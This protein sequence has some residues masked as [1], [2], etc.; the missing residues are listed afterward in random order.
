MILTRDLH[1][2]YED[3]G[4]PVLKNI[5]MEIREGKHVAI[6]GPN[7]C[8]KTTLVKHLN[9]L[10]L[11]TA[12]EVLV[13]EMD[14]RDSRN[15]KG[16][17]Q[18]VGMVF[19]NP[20]DQIVGMTVEEDVAFGPGNLNM[21]PSE[22][23]NRVR[24]SLET[25]GMDSH[26]KRPPQALSNGEK[27]LVAIAGV[28]ATEPKYLILDE[29]TTYLDPLWKQ[30]VM[31]LTLDL[32]NHG[33]TIIHVTHGM[34]EAVQADLVFVM[35]HGEI[36]TKGEPEEVFSKRGYLEDMGLEIPEISKL[37]WRMR[38]MGIQVDPCV[39]TIDKA[40]EELFPLLSKPGGG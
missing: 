29:P 37:M 28:L 10:L 14:T 2:A 36:M 24:K 35:H 12:G 39:F 27:Q 4:T 31:E 16:I 19:Q 15:L 8:G 25:V 3:N 20:D 21:P 11:P 32:K 23:R 6:I 40:A 30:R 17:R 1:F 18:R 38:E 5:N 33:I 13:D 7:G 22:I 26:A 34:S 9:G